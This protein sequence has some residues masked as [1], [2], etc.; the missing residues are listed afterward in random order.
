MARPSGEQMKREMVTFPMGNSEF[1]K[2]VTANIGAVVMPW[3]LAY[4]QSAVCNKGLSEDW[5]EHLLLERID[6][7]LG[8]FLTQA[9]MAAMLVTVATVSKPGQSVDDVSDLLPIFT[10]VLRGENQ[11]KWLLTFA[12]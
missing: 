8:S 9:V 5:E 10:E 1:V 11:A 4:Q 12:V 2:L 3:M 6:T 7:A